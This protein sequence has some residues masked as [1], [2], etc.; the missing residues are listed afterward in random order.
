MVAINSRNGKKPSRPARN[1]NMVVS[2]MRNLSD[3]NGCTI[4]NIVGFISDLYDKPAPK[5]EVNP[6]NLFQFLIY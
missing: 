4:G 6:D 3:E 1:V 2:A 5:R